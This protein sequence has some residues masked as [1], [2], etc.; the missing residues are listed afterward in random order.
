MTVSERGTSN[1]MIEL[2]I[3]VFFFLQTL[4]TFL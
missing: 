3:Y 2:D 4:D 1:K